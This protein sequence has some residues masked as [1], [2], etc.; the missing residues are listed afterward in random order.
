MRYKILSAV[1]IFLWCSMASFAATPETAAY[2]LIKRMV[3][4]IAG[5]FLVETI[6]GE[7]Q[8]DVFEIASAGN[9]IVL[10]GN[11]AVAIASAFH[12]YLKY[13]CKAHF[14]WNGKQ[15]N[16]PRV[17]PPV[18]QQLR[19][20]IQPDY[21]VY[22]NYCTLSY[23]AAW[24]NW[25]RWQ[26]EID[27]MAMNGI[28]MPLAAVGLEGVWY[29]S[30]LKI[31]LTDKEARS[32]LVGPAYFA[33]Q[34]MTN[35]ESFGGPLPKRWIDAHIVLGKKIIDREVELGMKPIQQGFSG[36][37]PRL[38]MQKFPG[39]K[40]KRTNGW[41]QSFSG[42]AQLDPLD[43]LFA[44]FGRIFLEEQRR[45]FGAHGYYAADPF[46]EGAP[47]QTDEAYLRSVGEQI[48]KLF[49]DF[50]AHSK[51]VMQAWSIRKPIATAV[52]KDRLLVLDLNGGRHKGLEGFWGYDFVVGNLHNFGGRINMHGDL[53]L[54]AA[55]QYQQVRKNY[56]NAVG[57]GL[58]M[59]GITQNPVYYDLAFEMPFHSDKVALNNWLHDYALRRYG[60]AD[61]DIDTAW[62]LLL[63]GPYRPGTNGV[64]ASSILAARPALDVKKSGPNAGFIMPYEP[65]ALQKV[66]TLMLKQQR[67]FAASDAYLFDIVDIE[68]QLLS[69]LG[70]KMTKAAADAFKAKDRP[71]FQKHS[72]RFLALMDDVDQLVGTRPEY[73]FHKWVSDARSWG[74]TPAEKALYDWNASMLVTQW[75]GDRGDSLYGIFDYSWR[76]WGGLIRG[77]INPGGSFFTRCWT[78]ICTMEQPITKPGCRRYMAAKQCGPMLFTGVLQIGRINGSSR[79]KNRSR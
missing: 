79:R 32:F 7:G 41:A 43:P 74:T 44:T 54:V 22:M 59:E 38:F 70:Q 23:S 17:L 27:Y 57:Y 50:D 49:M 71:A 56:P 2:G 61:R 31:G 30:L 75:G 66:L 69:N 45:L 37:V 9:K 14:S 67:R 73:S 33:W 53:Q 19:K 52:P 68:R 11:N 58:F 35:I 12:W 26:W 60:G 76:E 62:Q 39:A 64:E 16:Y 78:G 55:N 10:R 18:K 8:K 34:W 21:R 29:H 15:L 6:A 25:E 1:W 51:W 36:F 40:I 4:Q 24:W 46:H 28:N 13:Y 63:N 42:V 3:P 48:N 47:P 72:A 20:V 5:H 65:L 77:I